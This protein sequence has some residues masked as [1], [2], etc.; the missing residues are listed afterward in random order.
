MS[1]T[2]YFTPA[3]TTRGWI[4]VCM[5]I[6]ASASRAVVFRLRVD[7]TYMLRMCLYR[8]ETIEWEKRGEGVGNVF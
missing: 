1:F 3:S 6:F 8:R 4:F 5:A 7:L 2:G